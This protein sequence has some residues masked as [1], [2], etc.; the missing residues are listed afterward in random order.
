[1]TSLIDEPRAFWAKVDKS[2]DC[3]LWTAGLNNGYGRYVLNRQKYYAH[4]FAY[5]LLVGP[6]P[7]GFQIDHLCRVTAC[8]NPAHLEAVTQAENNRRSDSISARYVRRTHCGAGHEY[9]PENT[10]IYRNARYC[11]ECDRI[12]KRANQPQA[13]IRQRA[14]RATNRSAA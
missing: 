4:R 10:H 11:R 7:D 12:E 1:M 5:E 13:T 2:G 8:V 14:R 9:T 6:I 3:W